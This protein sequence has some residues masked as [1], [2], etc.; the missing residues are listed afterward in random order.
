MSDAT[1]FPLP[2]PDAVSAPY[3]Q[4]LADGHLAFQRCDACNGTWLPPR[5]ECPHCLSPRWHWDRASGRGKLISWVVY[6]VPYHPAFADRVPYA[7]AVVELAE[8]P[9]LI[10][11]V[12][13]A[14]DPE[15]LRI[16]QD[17]TLAIEQE[18]GVAV[19]RFRPEG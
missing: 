16:D 17:L 11:N 9:R 14:P 3:W 13:D 15:A 2:Q 19:A 5:A 12:I 6:H 18:H 10:S 4:A 1:G 7:V 8:G